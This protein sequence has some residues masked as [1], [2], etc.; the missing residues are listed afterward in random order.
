VQ[1]VGFAGID[2]IEEALNAG[3]HGMLEALRLSEHRIPVSLEQ[4]DVLGDRLVRVQIGQDW[5]HWPAIPASDDAASFANGILSQVFAN[6]DLLVSEELALYLWTE[7]RRVAPPPSDPQRRA[8][9]RVLTEAILR[10][11]P[12]LEPLRRYRLALED[13]LD[14]QQ[15][16]DVMEPAYATES[17]SEIVVFAAPSVLK[18]LGEPELEGVRERIFDRFGVAL[19]ELKARVDESKQLVKT[20]FRL[21]LNALTGFVMRAEGPSESDATHS[22]EEALSLDLHL[23]LTAFVFEEMLGRFIAGFPMP[24]FSTIEVLGTARLLQVLRMLLTEGV[25]IRDLRT[26][27]S[28]LLELRGAIA[29]TD[30]ELEGYCPTHARLVPRR[31]DA[32][33]GPPT[34]LELANY[35]RIRLRDQLCLSCAEPA[36]TTLRVFPVSRRLEGRLCALVAAPLSSEDEDQ[37]AA[38]VAGALGPEADGGALLT[39]FHCRHAVWTLLRRRFP[40]LRV[41]CPQELSP[42]MEVARQT[43]VDCDLS[44]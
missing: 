40:R 38:A 12:P 11:C 20:E 19:P 5:C 16:F 33:E 6:R 18:S 26:I 3:I 35:A 9:R 25:S 27:L 10:G 14:E 30:E 44:S 28:A 22:I 37:L 13:G 34:T 17:A 15:L 32:P 24:A 42:A 23:R 31:P 43:A 8:I 7:V 21:A 36:T 29:L 41:L 1:R 39:S 4:E 2:Q